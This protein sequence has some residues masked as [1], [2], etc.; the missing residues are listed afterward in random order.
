MNEGELQNP[1]PYACRVSIRERFG[2][3]R[4]IGANFA[5]VS[6]V[7]PSSR[8]LARAMVAPLRQAQRNLSGS[9][10]R[11][12]EMGSGT[13]A[14][15]RALGTEMQQQDCLVCY[16]VNSMF[17][18]YLERRIAE[19]P[20]FRHVRSQI[21]IQRQPAEE[22]N[23]RQPFD[24]VVC[25]LPLNNLPPAVVAAVF[26]AG[27]GALREG[28]VFTYCSYMLPPMLK[29][30]FASSMKRRHLEEV[31]RIKRRYREA[32]VATTSLVWLNLLPA[33]VHHISV[34][35]LGPGH[36]EA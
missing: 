2:F 20:E 24:F 22:V 23:S 15:T 10:L 25:S 35:P 3:V 5:S 1:I 34:S 18:D 26:K 11:I 31:M 36:S 21:T 29:S 27:F 33:R 9:G 32:Q 4:Q 6:A 7:Q 14:I 16:E 19:D 8:Y 30:V 13:G 28:G 12:A 17:A